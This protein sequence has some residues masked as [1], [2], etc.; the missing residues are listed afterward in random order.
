MLLSLED[1]KVAIP[2]RRRLIGIDL[3]SKT[4]GL[5]LSDS[6]WHVASPLMTIERTSFKMDARQL[7]ALLKEHTIGGVV[8]GFPLNMN[9]TEG[10]R[11][12]STRSFVDNFLKMHDIP[13]VLWD[14]RLSTV[15][16]HRTMIE[17][18][19]SRVRQAQVVDKMAASFILQGALDFLRNNNAEI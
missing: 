17:G 9:G 16:V 5:S 4:I 2:V 1:F 13:V 6:S 15:A 11:C 7:I 19:L 18:D 8:I 12:Q 10:P 14:E 3:G